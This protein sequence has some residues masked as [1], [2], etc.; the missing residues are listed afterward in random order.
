MLVILDGWGLREEI[1]DNAVGQARTPVFDGLM[2]ERP[3]ARLRTFGADVG[4]PEGQMGNSEVGHLNIGAGRVVLQDLPRIDTAVADGSLAANPALGRFIERLRASG[5]TCHL[6]G[7]LSPGGVHAHQDHAVALARLL[8]AAGVPVRLHG[9]TDGRDMPPRSAA[10]CIAA[11]ETALPPGARIATL[12][13]RYFAM[14]RDRRWERVQ[15]AYDALTAGRGTRF[16]RAGQAVAAAYAADVSDEFM[17]PAVIGDFA[18]MRDG[19]GLLSFNFRADR[20]RQILEALL[21]PAFAGFPRAGTIRFAAAL[22]IVQYSLEIDAFAETLFGPLDLPN[23]LGETVARAGRTQLRMA[24]TEKYP[25]VTYF[26]NGGLEAPFPGQDAVLVPSPKVATYDLQPEMSAA[27]LTDRAVAAIGSGAYDLIILNFAN[28][29]MVGHTGSL[30]AAVKAVE[31]VDA[32]LGRV[33]E[34]V[35]AQGGALLVT[36]DHG[37][38]ETMRDPE[39]GEP[40]TAH[41]LN[42]VPVTLVGVDGVVLAD[43]RLADVAPT[44]LALMGLDQP[45]EMTGTSLIR[46]AG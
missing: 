25:H 29:D 45:A 39:T 34:A 7:L 6:V 10:A 28:P 4:L 46:R 38:C 26:M 23:G 19:D 3:R 30:A 15:I 13:G 24:E 12:C 33:V 21:D 31:T 42:P 43:G 22:G 18:G 37:N 14:D 41:T 20:T 9:F 35:T 1:A 27:E 32:C 44:L 8:V 40:H 17:R 16:A 36:A 2:R 11:V 5:G